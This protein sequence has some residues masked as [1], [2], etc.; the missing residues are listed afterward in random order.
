MLRAT[1]IFCLLSLGGCATTAGDWSHFDD[2][3]L[4]TW[5]EREAAPWF[6]DTLATH[7]RFSSEPVR[8]AVMKDERVV[9]GADA[10]SIS[11]RDRLHARLLE[12]PAL[13]VSIHEPVASCAPAASGYLLGIE[14][15]RSAG[16][17]A[18]LQLRIYDAVERVWVSGFALRWQGRLSAGEA[19][20]AA[21]EVVPDTALGTRLLPFRAAQSDL[22][23]A[24]LAAAL[25]CELRRQGRDERIVQPARHRGPALV[26][27][28]LAARH[29]IAVASAGAYTLDTRVHDV[30]RGLYQVWAILTPADAAGELR[31]IAA[32]A[33]ASAPLL[34]PPAQPQRVVDAQQGAAPAAQPAAAYRAPLPLVSHA[35]VLG[36]A[37]GRECEQREV[38]LR[39]PARGNRL[40]LGERECFAI[41]FEATGETRIY[42]V[43]RETD[44]RTVRV[45]P[46]GCVPG[47]LGA[48]RLAS[49][50]FP[51]RGAIAWDR[52]GGSETFFIIGVRGN[53]AAREVERLL[54]RLPGAC[55]P[56]RARDP[57]ASDWP[58]QLERLV[59]GLGPAAGFATVTVHHEDGHVARRADHR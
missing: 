15:Q 5:L 3:S 50:R 54:D 11:V 49:H 55:D 8:L 53:D 9:L 40:S 1:F 17:P 43:G 13:S 32:S 56:V 41:E 20:M 34:R 33:Y 21:R 52:R 18:R 36:P 6:A 42:I 2:G 58:A 46:S 39:G 26:A 12:V 37:R 59:T 14:L 35:A 51:A 23:A 16:Q 22:L 7:P 57:A 31:S 48:G 25:A 4:A 44:A 47:G 27:G 38:R 28:N 45:H 10:L 24:Q 19:R 29:A 30:D